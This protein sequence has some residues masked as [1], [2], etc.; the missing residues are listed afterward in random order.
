MR[1]LMR[2]RARQTVILRVRVEFPNDYSMIE[3]HCRNVNWIIGKGNSPITETHLRATVTKH[4]IEGIACT[5]HRKAY[6]RVCQIPHRSGRIAERVEEIAEAYAAATA[7]LVAESPIKAQK[8]GRCRERVRD[9][10]PQF[11]EKAGPA[12]GFD[13][14]QCQL[15]YRTSPLPPASENHALPG[16]GRRRGIRFSH[17]AGWVRPGVLSTYLFHA[18]LHTSCFANRRVE[19]GRT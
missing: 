9:R 14:F 18:E 15:T 2:E 13:L 1:T 16:G 11:A 7:P 10:A 19:T 3:C 6:D 5:A 17:H 12:H 8:V 4:V